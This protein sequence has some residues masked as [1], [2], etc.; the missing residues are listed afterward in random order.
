M[1]WL[2]LRNGL[3]DSRYYHQIP[4]L[5]CFITDSC[6]RGGKFIWQSQRCFVDNIQDNEL[7]W[8]D[9]LERIQGKDM[10]CIKIT[11]PITTPIPGCF[12]IAIDLPFK[13]IIYTLKSVFRLP[14]G[15]TRIGKDSASD[16]CSLRQPKQIMPF[17][18]MWKVVSM[19]WRRVRL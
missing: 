16:T 8:S 9:L 12:W 14:G 15:Q 19:I 4:V 2:L 7:A 5:L 10:G 11:S 17:D 13:M 6:N 1:E 3:D 18:G